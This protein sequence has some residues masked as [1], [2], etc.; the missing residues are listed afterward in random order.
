MN[1]KS[2]DAIVPDQNVQT[3]AAWKATE[4]QHWSGSATFPASEIDHAVS[5]PWSTQQR[6][7]ATCSAL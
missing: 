1:M 4:F 6:S 7:Q 3:K 2:L 5:I